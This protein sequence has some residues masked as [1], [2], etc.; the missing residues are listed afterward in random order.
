[1]VNSIE[2]VK[3]FG[4]IAHVNTQTQIHCSLDESGWGIRS[5]FEPVP[6]KA[7]DRVGQTDVVSLLKA[8]NLSLDVRVQ[9]YGRSH[10][11]SL[12]SKV[13]ELCINDADCALRTH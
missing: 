7:I 1:V 5:A 8:L 11:F 13:Q 10:V 4:D 9:A 3:C 12:T 6:G 2:K